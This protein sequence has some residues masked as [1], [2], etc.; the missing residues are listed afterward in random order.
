[1]KGKTLIT[2]LVTAV[3]FFVLAPSGIPV[4]AQDL[5]IGP[6]DIRLE[7][8]ASEGIHLFIRKK[9]GVGSVLLAESTRDPDMGSDNFA[10]RA[11]EW[12]PVNGDEIRILNGAPIPRSSGIFS[13]I[14]SSPEVHA[15]LGE[16]FHI[17]IPWIVEYGYEDSRRGEVYM[18]DGTYLNIRSYS[19]PYADYRG[20]FTDN[21]F[22][23]R[24]VQ[25]PPEKPEGVFMEEAEKAFNE[26]AREGG[27]DFTYAANPAD[28]VNRIDNI[29]RKETGKN[30]D[31]VLCLDTTASMEPY[32]NGLRRM[33]IPKMREITNEFTG[34][35]IGM[36][37][38]KDY[39]SEYLNRVIS[40]TSDFSVFQRN[41]N[42]IRVRGGGDTPEAVYEDLYEGADQFPWEAESRILVLVGDAHPHPRQ[43][44]KI[45]RE[46]AYQKIE[47]M[48]IKVDAII[49]SR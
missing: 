28:L 23:L 44:G 4:F 17:F 16:A 25:K 46:M 1:M 24:A 30:V 7:Q 48:G 8:D 2:Y 26:I 42:A 31:I 47:D 32:I 39:F 41:L 33:L 3:L 29:L 12:N 27:G 45:S 11:P 13:L 15:E 5:S 10:Y 21:P 9:P 38:Y 40:F 18:A 49:L 19:L 37:L 35:R 22:T 14:D 6:D 43:R 36:L 34:Y 20:A